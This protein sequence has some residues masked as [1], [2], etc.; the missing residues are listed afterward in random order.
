M[1]RYQVSKHSVGIQGDVLYVKYVAGVTL[2]E[3]QQMDALV[4]PHV[5]PLLPIYVVY[6]VSE[7]GL[8]TPQARRHSAERNKEMRCSAAVIYGTTLFTR[9]A[10]ALVLSAVRL[11]SKSLPEIAYVNSELEADAWIAAHRLR[12]RD[13]PG[14]IDKR[15]G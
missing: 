4:A 12:N 5:D 14:P 15:L 8:M 10:I 1:Q 9:A 3:L 13:A 2:E 7:A 6:D 11:I